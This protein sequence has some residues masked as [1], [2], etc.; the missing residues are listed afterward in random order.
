[1]KNPFLKSTVDYLI[2]GLGNPGLEYEK[3]RHNLGFR[4]MD[5]LCEQQGIALERVKFNARFAAGS[6][7][8]KRCLFLKPQTYMN[9]SGESVA[10]AMRF[11]KLHPEQ[12]LVIF[13]D[14]S[15]PVG[16]LRIRQK[17]SAGGHNGIKSII[18]L[19]GSDAFLRIKIGCGQK[20]TP[21]YNLAD[22]VLGK[23]PPEDEKI[24]QQVLPRAAEAVVC[25][26]EKG[27]ESAMGRYNG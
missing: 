2:V 21:A 4:C 3:T 16:R 15:L 18:E 10:A 13:D 7:G 19:L 8:A 5:T 12:L 6:L 23:F 26:V 11:Y 27:V 25:V 24:I 14:I 1:M 17:G 22:W 20:P 9:N